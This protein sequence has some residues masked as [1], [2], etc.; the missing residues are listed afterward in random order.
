MKNFKMHE[1]RE[2]KRGRRRK[3]ADEYLMLFEKKSKR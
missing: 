2:L 3:I 1:W